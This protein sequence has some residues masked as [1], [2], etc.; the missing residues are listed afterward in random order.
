ME[1]E[2]GL[3]GSTN[4][5]LAM[6]LI[7]FW[8]VKMVSVRINDI[9]FINGQAM[10]LAGRVES[11]RVC[12]GAR[13]FLRTPVVEVQTS[14]VGLERNRQIVPYVS[15]GETVAVTIR[16]IHPSQLAGGVEFIESREKHLSPWRVLDLVVAEA[17]RLWWEFWR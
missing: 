7:F 8:L 17:P 9:F 11:G 12:I 1:S 2:V 6:P 13:V 5:W 14:L 10:V 3:T 15:S 16:D 4:N